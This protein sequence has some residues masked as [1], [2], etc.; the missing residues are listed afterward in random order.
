LYVLVGALFTCSVAAL[1]AWAL[2]VVY[3]VRVLR[4]I[5][6]DVSRRNRRLAYNPANVVFHPELLTPDGLRYRQRLGWSVA[7]FVGLV[8]GVMLLAM[9][10]AA[11]R[12]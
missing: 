11:S 7:V 5:R 2:I 1:V 10:I 9:L 12:A 4:N 3:G 6:P 8:L